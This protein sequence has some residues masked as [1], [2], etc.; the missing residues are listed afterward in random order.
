MTADPHG[1]PAHVRLQA[2]VY[3]SVLALIVGWVLYIGKSVIV[4]VV[5]ATL[6][7]FVIVGVTRQLARIPVLGP[8]LP[9]KLRYALSVLVTGGALTLVALVALANL[10]RVA[11]RAPLYQATLLATIQKLAVRFGVEDE[12]TWGTLRQIFLEQVSLQA[13]IGSSVAIAA[14]IVGGVIVVLLYVAFLLLEQRA[15]SDKI[16]RVAGGPAN[17]ARVRQIFESVNARVG[18]YLAL[19]TFLGFLQGVLSFG[20]MALYGLEFA[21]FWSMLMVLFNYVPYIGSFLAVALPVAMAIVQF[22]DLATVLTLL[23][24]LFVVQFVIGNFLDPYLL[25]NSLNLSPFVILV[26]L[27]VWS[28]LWGVSGAFLAVPVTAVLAIVFSEF[29]ATRPIAVLLSRSGNLSGD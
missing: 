22:G 13:L 14:S 11:A 19:K 29:A 26:S 28:G 7:A 8:A 5:L 3:G 20:I 15:F 25:G 17:A 6:V 9:L 18:S 2:F 16:D 4:P 21:A 24:G 12:P 23:A 27:T 1:A 10:D